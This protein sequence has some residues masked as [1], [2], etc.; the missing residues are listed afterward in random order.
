MDLLSTTVPTVFQAFAET[1]RRRPDGEFLYQPASAT[2]QYANGAVS[3]TYA[4]AMSE[5]ESIA[6]VYRAAGLGPGI[7]VATLLENRPEAHFHWFALNSLGVS[8]VPINPDYRASEIQHILEHSESRLVISIPERVEE[9]R[10]V[11]TKLA[12]A[13][14]VVSSAAVRRDGVPLKFASADVPLEGATECAV[15]YTSGTTGRPKGCLLSN[16]YF[17]RSGLR[18]L[19]RAG[20]ISLQRD[21]ER[22]LTPLPMF[23]MNAMASTTLSMILTGGCVILLDRFHPGSWWEDVVESRATGIHYLGVMPA[24]LLAK[25]VSEAETKHMV[26]YGFGANVEASHHTAFEERFSFPLIEGWAMTE[27]G[28]GASMCADVEPRHIGTHCFGRAPADIDVR[29]VDGKMR[30]V[31]RGEVG[32]M[33]VRCAGPDP[34]LGF[35][36]GYLKDPLATE[37][38]WEGGWWHTGD[39]VRQGPDDSLHYVDRKKNIIRRSG[40]NIS[41]FEV[42]EILRMND[43]VAQ[44]AVTAVAD[45]VRGDEVLACIVPAAGAATDRDAATRLVN[46]M[47]ERAAYFKAP[48]WV[49][50]VEVLPTTATQKLDRA[51][52]KSFGVELLASGACID[53]RSLKRRQ[54]H[55]RT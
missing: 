24:I 44:V 46:W 15:L 5:V 1:S 34:R 55:Q 10:A 50:Y 53:T 30:D 2:R 26:R 41:A 33:I 7:R 48:G 22:L 39:L 36:S 49:A 16:D 42:E 47:I 13:V 32:E 17:I 31:A 54:N 8:V 9:L 18:Y 43:T 45:E 21:R 23:H 35:F 40:E 51:G 19:R 25:P 20:P 11:T 52:L 29:L 37:A 4:Q 28:S 27:T 6:S 12:S 3:F 14:P 38:G